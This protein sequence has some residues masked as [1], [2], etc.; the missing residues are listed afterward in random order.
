MKYAVF[1]P[2][3]TFVIFTIPNPYDPCFNL[4]RDVTLNPTEII[5][6]INYDLCSNVL[7]FNA[8]ASTDYKLEMCSTECCENVIKV[9]NNIVPTDS[10]TFDM[11]GYQDAIIGYYILKTSTINFYFDPVQSRYVLDTE[12]SILDT[13][14]GVLNNMITNHSLTYYNHFYATSENNIIDYLILNSRQNKLIV[15][16]EE[17]TISTEFKENAMNLFTIS[18]LNNKMTLYDQYS[19][20]KNNLYVN[21][22]TGNDIYMDMSHN[23]ASKYEQYIDISGA[24][25]LDLFFNM[26][27][28][29]N[30]NLFFFLLDNTG[31]TV[32]FDVNEDVNSNGNIFKNYFMIND[33]N[34]KVL[35]NNH[36]NNNNI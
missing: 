10:F 29:H 28:S 11:S 8:S 13:F 31:I 36:I 15:P 12:Y 33:H 20:N 30:V 17:L 16:N 3:Y 1:T 2:I 18:S 7:Y 34:C 24:T 21:Y 35:F 22:C 9:V 5:D 25:D 14:I 19:K 32:N 27:N 6:L 26:I 4:I 23:N